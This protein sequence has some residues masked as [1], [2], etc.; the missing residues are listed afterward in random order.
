MPIDNTAALQALASTLK[1]ALTFND[2][3]V[4]DLVLNGDSLVTLEGNPQGTTLRING[5]VGNLPDPQ[6]P[7][8]L[9]LLLQANFNG[10]G[11]GPCSLG[12]DHVSGEVVLGRGVDVTTLGEAGLEPAVGEFANYLIYWRDNLL[13]LLSEEA[14]PHIDRSALLAAGPGMLA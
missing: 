1:I 7:Q 10:Q 8:A 14:M 9:R 5:V 3:D 11:T 2:D 6:A 4:C 13:R 12:L